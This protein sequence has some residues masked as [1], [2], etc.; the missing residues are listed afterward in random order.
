LA[1][2]RGKQAGDD[3]QENRFADTG[4]PQQDELLLLFHSQIQLWKFERA[5]PFSD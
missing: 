5:E 3:L 1:A 2:I 4:R